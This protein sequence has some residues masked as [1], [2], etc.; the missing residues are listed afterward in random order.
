ME[1][2]V[3]TMGSGYFTAPLGGGA[4]AP[5]EKCMPAKGGGG[6]GGVYI[7]N[8]WKSVSVRL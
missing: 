2:I 7:G 4:L 1:Q 6:G 8:P 5:L 3:L